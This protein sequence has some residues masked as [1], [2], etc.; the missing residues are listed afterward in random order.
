MAP[1][2]QDEASTPT[3]AAS[4]RRFGPVVERLRPRRGPSRLLGRFALFWL[5]SALLHMGVWAV[6]GGAW[7]GAISWR[8]PIVFSL[9]IGLLLWAFGWLLDQL[10]HRRRLAWSLAAILAISSTAENGLI[11]TQ[12]WRGEASHFNTFEATNGAIFAAMGAMVAVMSVTI[13]AGFVWSLIERP[14]DPIVRSALYWGF[15]LV[16]AGLGIGQW[17]ISLGNA[18]VEQFSQV[19]STVTYGD[20]GVVKFPHAIAFHGVQ[21]FMVAAAS[22]SATAGA[23][24]QRAR[25]LMRLVVASYLG[26]FAFSAVQTGSGRAPADVMAGT[27]ALLVLSTAVLVAALGVIAWSTLRL[28]MRPLPAAAPTR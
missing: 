28:T 17:I 2:P 23:H 3:A 12:T 24:R 11:I 19:P 14:S 25:T 15:A 18:Y 22:L 7:S 13:V 26:V 27:S 20:A 9:S 10:P 5:A 21:L 6:D 1:H 8:K 16:I 4:G